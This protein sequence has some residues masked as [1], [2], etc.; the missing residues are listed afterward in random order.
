[1]SGRSAAAALLVLALVGCGAG[2]E[3]EA[4]KPTPSPTSTSASPT[5]EPSESPSTDA[6]A[7]A[8]EFV[9]AVREKVPEIT[10]DRT[11]EEIAALG[12]LAC[13]GL[14]SGQTADQLV[15][16]AQSLG[17]LDATATDPATARELLKLAID[18]TCPDQAGRVDE[19]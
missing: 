13:Q 1:M 18:T 4:D 3:T 19:F 15:A 16:A 5:P 2:D 8:R 9:A 10:K 12:L 17:T 6:S 14:S 11:D 7:A